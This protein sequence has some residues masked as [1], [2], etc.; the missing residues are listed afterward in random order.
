MDPS[1]R[2]DRLLMQYLISHIQRLEN[3]KDDLLDEITT[4]NDELNSTYP[5]NRDEF[6]S[7]VGYSFA[8]CAGSRTLLEFGSLQRFLNEYIR[9]NPDHFDSEASYYVPHNDHAP[10]ALLKQN[11]TDM[12]KTLELLKEVE[13]IITRDLPPAAIAKIHRSSHRNFQEYV[14]IMQE[15]EDPFGMNKIAYHHWHALVRLQKQIEYLTTKR[16]KTVDALKKN[17]EF[18]DR[19]HKE[20]GIVG[21]RACATERAKIVNAL[22]ENEEEKKNEEEGSIAWEG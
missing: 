2:K 7:N 19:M 15:Y 11:A 22:K 18:L 4:Y 1:V 13:P 9:L 10:L 14:Q 8:N 20:F 3:K 16:D 17:E 6:A 5:H 21:G 12:H